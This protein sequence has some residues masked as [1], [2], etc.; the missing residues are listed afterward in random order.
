MKQNNQKGFTLIEI[1]AASFIL[2]IGMGMVGTIISSLVNANF[3]SLR[4]TQAVTLAQNKIEELINDGY[5]SP[6]LDEDS[7]ENP[8][9][10][11]GETGDTTG[12]FTQTWDVDD[13]NPIEKAKLITSRVSW[14]DANGEEKTVTLVGVCIDQSN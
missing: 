7:Y 2:V 4:H 12:V 5:S 14:T 11:V 3:H 13:V 1:I 9:N 6:K 10:P 8:L